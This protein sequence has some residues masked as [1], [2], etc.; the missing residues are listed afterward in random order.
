[1]KNKIDWNKI[2]KF[3]NKE[4]SEE[5]MKNFQESM[6]SE[7]RKEFKSI[8]KTWKESGNTYNNA[9]PDKNKMWAVIKE[10]TSEKKVIKLN[11]NLFI[12]IA[13]SIIILFII[14]SVYYLMNNSDLKKSELLVMNSGDKSKIKIELKDGS[15]V[16]LN[17]QTILKYPEKFNKNKREVYLKGEAFFDIAE[18]KQKPFI[19]YTQ[20]TSVKVRG[21]EFNVR[22]YE[23]DNEVSVSVISGKVKFTVNEI[24]S[25]NIELEKGENGIFNQSIDTLIL[26]KNLNQNNFSWRT[27]K[28]VFTETEMPEVCATLSKHYF[29]K[30][31]IADSAI[32]SLTFTGSFEN[33]MLEEVLSLMDYALGVTHE[34]KEDTILLKVNN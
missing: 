14:A 1:V 2:G 17:K 16:W 22:A 7:D 18:N 15:I 20:K 13:A 9:K 23:H 28:I 32:K 24:P 4:L 33:Q 3:L 19:I 31:K 27:G 25:K 21:T 26:A 29:Q 30:I 5:E 8:Q 34:Y 12:R 11:F 10:E 6:N